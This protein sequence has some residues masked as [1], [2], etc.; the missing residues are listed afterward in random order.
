MK[1]YFIHANGSNAGPYSFED[2]RAMRIQ[3]TTP[4]WYDGL[5]NWTNAG[6]I[7]ELNVL[8]TSNAA[9]FT[10]SQNYSKP[11][12][13]PTYNF[14][15]DNLSGNTGATKP[16]KSFAVILV[17]VVLFIVAIG[18]F[19]AY[20][21]FE[22]SQAD[23]TLAEYSDYELEQKRIENGTQ[24][25]I[26]SMN[27]AIAAAAESPTDYGITAYS[28]RFNDYNGGIL[29]VAGSDDQH[30]I[31]T[32][33][34]NGTGCSGTV[35]GEGSLISENLVQVKTSG[36]CKL[37]LKY[38]VGFVNVEESSGCNTKHGEGCSFDGIYSREK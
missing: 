32:L 26:D 5:G 2:L 8:F 6:D 16:V 10:T 17:G 28:G 14:T 23:R 37:T 11:G 7:D 38:S 31:V 35:S 22:Q 12:T 1:K 33:I 36:G 18:G 30:L 4:V 9:T 3:K 13:S 15:D 27:K 25:L 34:Y 20:K 24:A 19:V 29:I 21:I